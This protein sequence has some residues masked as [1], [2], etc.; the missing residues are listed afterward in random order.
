M[1]RITVKTGLLCS[2]LA[3]ILICI[4]T[5]ARFFSYLESGV[6]ISKLYVPALLWLIILTDDALVIYLNYLKEVKGKYISH[7]KPIIYYVALPVLI[8]CVVW[9]VILELLIIKLK[10][11]LLTP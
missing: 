10:P 1:P 4:A 11:C 9:A 3:L 6:D 2:L 7:Y 5:L 8:I